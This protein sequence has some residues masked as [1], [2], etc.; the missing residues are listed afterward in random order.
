MKKLIV[1]KL[2]NRKGE[3]IGEVLVSLLISALALVMLASMITSSSRMIQSSK[4]KLQDYY[5]ANNALETRTG[6]NSGTGTVLVK[7]GGTQVK[8]D[9]TKTPADLPSVSYYKNAKAPS[10]TQVVS[11]K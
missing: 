10:G 3:S 6:T 5:V 8:F 1:R 4:V 9:V 7:V 2:K 11:Y